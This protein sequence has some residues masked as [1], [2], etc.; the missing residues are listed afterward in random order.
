MATIRRGITEE[1]VGELAGLHYLLV[2]VEANSRNSIG[3]LHIN[4]I[5]L[6]QILEFVSELA[7]VLRSLDYFFHESPNLLVEG[8]LLFY[9]LTPMQ[10]DSLLLLPVSWVGLIGWRRFRQF[11]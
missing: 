8:F 11:V 9:L 1:G 10:G 5:A 2:N 7:M 3:F 4:I 6:S